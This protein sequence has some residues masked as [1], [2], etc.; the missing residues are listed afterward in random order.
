MG[1]R[2]AYAL[3]G[4]RVRGVGGS[5]LHW[6][7]YA[8][9]LHADDFRDALAPRS[10]RRLAAELRRPETRTM[11]RAEVALGVAG[12]ADE[13]WGS[14][15]STAFPLPEFPFSYSDGRFARA[16][17]RTRGIGFHHL[18]QARNSVAYDGRPRCQACATCHVCPT[19]AKASIDLTHVP[20][21]ESTGNVRI[22][23]E[24]NV[25]RLE[26]DDTGRVVRAVYVHPDRVERRLTASLFVPRRRRHRERAAPP[27]VRVAALSTWPGQPQWLRRHA[28]HGST[29]PST[30]S[31]ASPTTSIPIAS[32][33]PRRCPASSPS[34]APDRCGRA[35]C[36]NFS[37][38]RARG[39]M[40]S[41]SPADSPGDALARHV[42]AEFGTRLGIRIYSEHLPIRPAR[43]R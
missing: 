42:R 26:T 40:R 29:R 7:G 14:P 19:G 8:L 2:L 15:R 1:G 43:S 16:P 24:A 36:W 30:L 23:P 33:F 27:A 22:V 18:P 28:V 21:A 41:H 4:R 9:R 17:A 13:P 39:P 32:A 35:S 37:T 6:E 31:D 38:R 34:I 20:A 3:D 25:V 5:T 12:V 10:G 11:R